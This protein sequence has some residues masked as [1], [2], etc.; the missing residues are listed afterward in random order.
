[1]WDHI[2]GDFVKWMPMDSTFMSNYVRYISNIPNGYQV[3]VLKY[4]GT[5][6]VMLYNWNQGYWQTVWTSTHE[7]STGHGW[8]F[9]EGYFWT[10][11]PTSQSR[12]EAQGI[13][14]Y[15]TSDNNWHYVDILRG[16]PEM[17]P[18]PFWTP[19]NVNWVAM[20]HD[21]QIWE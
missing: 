12:I 10:P 21:W 3:E 19:Y 15:D 16:M 6:Y 18:F 5:W 1:V 4:Q 13:M 14:E 17:N 11:Y 8:D 20:Y 9:W 7:M 2:E